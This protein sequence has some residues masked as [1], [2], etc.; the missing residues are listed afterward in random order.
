MKKLLATIFLFSLPFLSYAHEFTL[1]YTG[2]SYATLYPCGSCPASVGGGISRRAAKIKDT[3]AKI[4]NV[5]VIDGGNFTGSGNLD[6]SSVN[7]EIDKK[8]TSI[9]Y[10]TMDKIGYD[11]AILGEA[12]FN[13]GLGFVSANVNNH[14]FKFISA[15]TSLEGVLPYF[16]KEFPSFKVAVVGLSPLSLYKKVGLNVQGYEEALGNVFAKLKNKVDFIIVASAAGDEENLVIAKKF[17]EINV[18][19]STGGNVSSVPNEKIE[20]T[21]ILR[22]SYRAQELRMVNF[23]IKKNKIIKWDFKKETLAL[24][25]PEATE[26]REIIPACFGNNDCPRKEGLISRCQDPG[27]SKAVCAYYEPKK[28]E[29]LLITDEECKFCATET[30]RNIL[31][32]LFLGI[33]FKIVDYRNN[34]AKELIKKY[35]IATIPC[36]ILPAEIKNEEDFD[37]VSKMFE[38]KEGKF[39]LKKELA[40]L[41]LF[42]QRKEVARRIDFFLDLYAQNANKILEDL[43]EFQKNNK[44]SLDIHIIIS[45]QENVG[46]PREELKIALAIKKLFPQKFA[47][48]L[49]ER[50][51]TIRSVSYN[52]SL[53]GL[54]LDYKNILNLSKS[55]EMEKLIKENSALAEEVSVNDGN[56]I[57]VNNKRVFKVF[58][59]ETKDLKKFF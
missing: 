37:T 14:K 7:P 21:I 43:I 32:S 11:A 16:I 39:F 6:R 20:D 28:I 55:K 42:L 59:I 3:K 45:E 23:E 25:T 46:Y 47:A 31:K 19:L 15:N 26:V 50:T 54:G 8:R 48:Y 34:R 5:L 33:N 38:E 2:N 13:F 51:K 27:E 40:G 52:D 30:P 18:I 29:A 58:Q 4:K 36:F 9:Y 24:D 49:K 35:S 12:E 22:P 10:A 57:L 17:K 41:F 53:N 44:V 56:V 1:V